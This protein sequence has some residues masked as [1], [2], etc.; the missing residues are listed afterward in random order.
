[1]SS[2]N[3]W[4]I[5]GTV[6]HARGFKT[7][8]KV[9]RTTTTNQPTTGLFE[10]VSLLKQVGSGEL[11]LLSAARNSKWQIFQNFTR[12]N[13]DGVQG[14][15]KDF[16]SFLSHW[17]FLSSLNGREYAP[18]KNPKHFYGQRFLQFYDFWGLTLRRLGLWENKEFQRKEI[19]W[20]NFLLFCEIFSV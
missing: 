6:I 15:N 20:I 18:E 2:S 17:W 9:F 3:S 13:K 1:M 7:V 14:R 12:N 19:G 11:L 4:E 5:L 16:L 8:P 10:Y